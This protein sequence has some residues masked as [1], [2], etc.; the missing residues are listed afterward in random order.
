MGPSR[1]TLSICCGT[2]WVFV[3]SQRRLRFLIT[4]LEDVVEIER[5]RMKGW[6]RGDE[7]K[8]ASSSDDVDPF[9]WRQSVTFILPS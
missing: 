3:Q 2:F 1:F 7:T 6:L 5:W 9:L 4:M 8:F